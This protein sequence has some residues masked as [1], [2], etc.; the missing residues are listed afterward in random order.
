MR[1]GGTVF[2]ALAPAWPPG[3]AVRIALASHKHS[4][5]T[6][7]LWRWVLTELG[8]NPQRMTWEHFWH[9][10]DLATILRLSR[11]VARSRLGCVR[12]ALES[13]TP[14]N[15]LREPHRRPKLAVAAQ[16]DSRVKPYFLFADD[17]WFGQAAQLPAPRSN[18]T[19][20]HTIL[21]NQ[22]Q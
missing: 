12:R 22:S 11:L 5:V 7:H 15:R 13:I 9:E 16:R 4:C 21:L 6:Q 3:P 17:W 19:V 20:P 8:P 18:A 1:S 2:S 10:I 14:N